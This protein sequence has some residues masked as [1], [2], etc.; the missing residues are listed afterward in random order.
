M[1]HKDLEENRE[2][3]YNPTQ[4]QTAWMAGLFD[5]EGCITYQNKTSVILQIAMNDLDIL[6]RF[7][8]IVG[9]GSIYK[10][11]TH[12]SPNHNYT[13]TWR[14][15]DRDNVRRLLL[16]MLPWFG[17][18]RSAKTMEALGRIRRNRGWGRS[19]LPE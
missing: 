6:E 16:L 8:S 10:G 2:Y 4:S 18:R 5:G 15:S 7:Q 12:R 1:T 19:P 11:T 3:P 14:V 9:C 13:Y 17:E